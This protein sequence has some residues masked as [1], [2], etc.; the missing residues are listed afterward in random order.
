MHRSDVSGG[1]REPG[2]D[3]PHRLVG[4]HDTFRR[5][6]VGQGSVELPRHHVLRAPLLAF[7][8]RLADADDGQ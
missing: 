3:R 1:R 6:T 8:L 5:G 2:S 4:H 7:H